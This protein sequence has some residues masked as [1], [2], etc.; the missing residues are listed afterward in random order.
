MLFLAKAAAVVGLA[1]GHVPSLRPGKV[2]AGT[3][4]QFFKVERKK[5]PACTYYKPP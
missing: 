5:P 4:F 2:L 1:L 3:F